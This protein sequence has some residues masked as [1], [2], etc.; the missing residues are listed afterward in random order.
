M[1]IEIE[2]IGDEGGTFCLG[3]V[4]GPLDEGDGAEGL[5]C[6]AGL[7][8]PRL[9]GCLE[10]GNAK[11]V[12]LGQIGVLPWREVQVGIVKGFEETGPPRGETGFL[13]HIFQAFP[14]TLRHQSQLRPAVRP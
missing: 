12:A 5:E 2:D 3:K 7:K 10:A 1:L 6:G 9:G 4:L 8:I 11:A 13:N 14:V